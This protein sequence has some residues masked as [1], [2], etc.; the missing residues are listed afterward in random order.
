MLK[1]SSCWAEGMIFILKGYLRKISVQRGY[2]TMFVRYL[3]ERKFCCR[4]Q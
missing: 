3:G 1:G 2:L 4:E